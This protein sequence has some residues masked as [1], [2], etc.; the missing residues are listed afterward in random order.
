MKT[1]SDAPS[2]LAVVCRAFLIVAVMVVLSLLAGYT[3]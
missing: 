2:I 3:P 1:N